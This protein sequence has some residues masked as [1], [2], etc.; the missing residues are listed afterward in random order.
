MKKCFSIPGCSFRK[1]V[2][3]GG[4]LLAGTLGTA[5]SA[6]ATPAITYGTYISGAVYEG[7]LAYHNAYET[8]GLFGINYTNGIL[9]QTNSVSDPSSPYSSATWGCK[10]EPSEFLTVVGVVSENGI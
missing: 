1:A 4:T 9:S 3:L 10:P 7:Y 2:F 5:T 6:F 8:G